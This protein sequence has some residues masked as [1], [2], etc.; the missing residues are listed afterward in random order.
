M[1]SVPVSGQITLSQ[2]Q[3][4]KMAKKEAKDLK[5]K[6]WKVVPGSLPMEV[7]IANRISLENKRDDLG[8]P[9]TLI[10]TGLSRGE[11]FDAANLSAMAVAKMNI[12]REL[13]SDFAAKIE[14]EMGNIQLPKNEAASV[15]EVKAA[16]QE[17]VN[18]KLGR[19]NP[20]VVLTHD[21]GNGN[22]EVMI[23]A[24]YPSVEGLEQAK[25]AIRAKLEA[26]IKGL[27]QK[28]DCLK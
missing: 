2:K 11:F 3:I 16:A 5:K 28:F 4:E 21:L 18:T 1:S 6:G 12:A 9:T 23:A 20:L 13:A 14:T 26:E 7:Q 19:V 25:N 17:L 8:R 24:G 22:V 10:Q 15:N 27:S